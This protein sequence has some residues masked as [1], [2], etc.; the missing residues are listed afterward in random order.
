M[1][2]FCLLYFFVGHGAIDFNQHLQKGSFNKKIIIEDENHSMPCSYD[3]GYSIH[4]E[5]DMHNTHHHCKLCN[6]FKTMSLFSNKL[7]KYMSSVPSG[8][9][10]N[11]YGQ[12]WNTLSHVSL[13]S[14]HPYD[15][16][17]AIGMC[18]NS[19]S[20]CP[21]HDT[22][23]KCTS[24]KFTHIDVKDFCQNIK[25]VY[26]QG[27]ID[28]QKSGLNS[29]SRVPSVSGTMKGSQNQTENVLWKESLEQQSGCPKIAKRFVS[30][31]FH[32]LGMAFKL[33]CFDNV[34]MG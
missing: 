18:Q 28:N 29:S 12:S 5:S 20:P 17:P 10:W 16:V 22:L 13:S 21:L 24:K 1:S 8:Y 23:H 32:D 19:L 27:T 3:L 34:L 11:T 33:E 7:I 2:H 31:S 9:P 14:W 26:M 30:V 15:S 25:P 6:V 4:E